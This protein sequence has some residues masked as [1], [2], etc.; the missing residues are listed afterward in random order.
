LLS[1]IVTRS[2]AIERACRSGRRPKARTDDVPLT[3]RSKTVKGPEGVLYTMFVPSTYDP[4]RPTPLLVGLHG[5]GQ[6]GKDGKEVVGSGPSAMNFYTGI[7][8]E[9]GWLVACPTAIQAPWNAEPN[10]PFLDAMLAE[11]GF[12][13]NVDLNRVYLT[14][15]SMGGYGTWHWGPEWAERWGAISPMAGGGGPAADRLQDTRT[16]VFVFHGADDNVVGVQ[17]D[18]A[19]A[20]V[21]LKNGNDFAYTELGGVGHG[22]PEEVLREMAD[23]FE[24]KRLAVR[25][26]G[27]NFVRSDEVRSSFLEKPT[28]EEKDYLGSPELPDPKAA[29]ETPEDRRARLLGELRLGG[30]RAEQ[31]AAAVGEAKDA[32]LLDPVAALLRN[33][34]NPVDVRSAAAKA[35]GG[36]AMPGGL[37]A[38]EGALGDES[39]P[40]Y[41]AALHGV[42]AVADR[43]SGPALLKALDFQARRFADKLQ[44]AGMDFSD[45]EG[46]CAALGA[47]AK[48]AGALSEGAAAVG[49]IHACVVKPVL[50]A[51]IQVP[52]STRVGQFPKVVK[53]RLGRETAEALGRTGHATAVPVLRAVKDLFPGDGDVGAACDEALAKVGAGK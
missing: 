16:F 10:G 24:V 39:D 12:L 21:L 27:K 31:A 40:V 38:L 34:K 33:A 15:H 43:R 4:L 26:G 9:H 46:R 17:G 41:L 45:Y 52:E 29:A 47:T 53:A 20:E 35:L 25:R 19:A 37:A 8:E 36:L 48:A 5:G 1:S 44:G 3:L 13:Y 30:G 51:R 23:W 50:E 18:R 22:C 14:G 42:E 28:K 7:A 6:A 2:F 11:L 49:R 32:K